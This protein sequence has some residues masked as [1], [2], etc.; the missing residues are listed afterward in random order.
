M[1]ERLVYTIHIIPNHRRINTVRAVAGQ[2]TKSPLEPER[3]SVKESHWEGTYGLWEWSGLCPVA[4]ML[5]SLEISVL[6][7]GCG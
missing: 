2:A 1:E 7:M 3:G 4:M 6:Q 5:G